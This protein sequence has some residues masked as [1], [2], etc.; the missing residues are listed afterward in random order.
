M[1]ECPLAGQH[2]EDLS[3][4]S[5]MVLESHCSFNRAL[6]TLLQTPFLHP[7]QWPRSVGGPWSPGQGLTIP[8]RGWELRTRF[9][10]LGR[11]HSLGPSP[12]QGGLGRCGLSLCGLREFLG[13]QQQLCLLHSADPIFS[14]QF[15]CNKCW[16]VGNNRISEPPTSQPSGN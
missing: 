10:S 4:A 7:P 1:A 13:A 14:L 15:S 9:Q 11:V 16:P 12:G 5:A 3:E 6:S 8:A 2:E